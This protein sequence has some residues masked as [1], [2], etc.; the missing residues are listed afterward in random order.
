MFPERRDCALV[1]E[2]VNRMIKLPDNIPAESNIYDFDYK[3]SLYLNK[4]KFFAAA[5]LLVIVNFG[6]F[7]QKYK[8]DSLTCY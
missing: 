6:Y 1:I 5:Q 7:L 4:N 8:T 2:L 3:F